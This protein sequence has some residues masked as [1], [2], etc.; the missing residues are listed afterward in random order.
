MVAARFL[1]LLAEAAPEEF[2][3]AVEASVK[4]DDAPITV[5][6]QSDG[7]GFFARDYV[8]DLTMALERLAWFPEYLADA[9]MALAA[10]A[11]KDTKESRHGNRPA[12]TLRQIFLLWHP[13][14]LAS[15]DARLAALRRLRDRYA[16][17]AWHLMVSLLPKYGG[18]ASSFSSKP[19]WRRLPTDD[20]STAAPATRIK[21]ASIIFD[22]LL[23]DAGR[24]V[25]R[26][27]EF[28]EN[29]RAL[30]RRPNAE[31]PSAS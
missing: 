24:V 25:S 18:D 10:L 21:D 22:W 28:L 26:W 14:T 9:T 15:A 27:K 19:V 11:D 12:G 3:E 7:E 4:R 31:R 13:Q 5:L 1:P 29:S 2:L 30:M 23:Q 16:N 8:S 17:V 6:L 20:A